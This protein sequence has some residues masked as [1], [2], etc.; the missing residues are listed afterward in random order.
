M[1]LKIFLYFIILSLV[2]PKAFSQEKKLAKGDKEFYDLAYIDAIAVYEKVAEKG[3]KSAGLF[4]KLGDSYYFNAEFEK[5]SKWYAELFTLEEKEIPTEYFYRYAQSLKAVGAYQK[6][7]SMLVKF[8]TV[9]SNEIR[10]SLFQKQTNYKEVIASNSGRY[11]IHDSGINSEY[12][13][14]GSSFYGNKIV[15]ASARDTGGVFRRNHKWTNE[16][17]TELYMVEDTANLA[18]AKPVK[19]SK[20]VNSKFNE[21]T[22]VFSK[23][24]QTLYFTRNNF[25][26]GKKGSDKNKT[27]LL[28]IYKA[29][30]KDSIWT[31]IKALAFTDDQ[32]NTAHPAL[33]ADGKTLYF[34]SDMPG[35]LGQS[36]LFKVEILADGSFG[37][38][39]H[40]GP[41]INTEGK[42]TF[43]FVSDDNELYFAS[44]GHPGL[45][46][47]DIFV[48][49]INED[50]AFAHPINIG[51]PVNSPTDD[52]AFIINTT[53][54]L[55]FFTSYR[56]G[57]KGM[58]DIYKFKELKP[59]SCEQV[60]KG[61]VTDMESGAVLSGAKVVLL[62]D[63]F[64]ELQ[65]MTATQD[66]MYV[67]QVAC[68]K[69]YHVRAEKEA[70]ETA[71]AKIIVPEISGETVLPI[72]PA[73]DIKPFNVGDDIGKKLAIKQIYFDL[74]KA[75]IRPD[76]EVELA[77][78]LEVLLQY[79][80]MRIDV[81]SHTDSRDSFKNN[82][83]LSER[84][85][86]STVAW[87]VRK[88]I[89]PERISGKGYGETQLI[90][91]C[92][93]GVKCSEEEHQLNRRSEFIILSI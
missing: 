44:D 36:D 1:K 78:V 4:Q 69:I 8:N 73:K 35:T 45:G 50:G 41:E 7:D 51:E 52:F 93:D 80:T 60:L 57:G 18:F 61:Q 71:E 64:V 86:Q 76:A 77:K 28:K 33:S 90:N 23:D 20:D 34:A 17:F 9:S 16:A 62:D 66:G 91:Q 68:G 26:D 88:G 59:L 56:K 75:A 24:G 85:A 92:A 39:I 3:Y 67:F 83:K 84:R 79:P 12:S 38:P 54:K 82:E 15:F 65:H 58:D 29:V 48:S 70:Y 5:A 81:R 72:A 30:F 32:Y 49:K 89:S 14:Y 37:T 46:G 25:L 43:P 13:D 40:L 22:P 55:G 63:K 27:T 47:L 2:L 6:A 31:D 11:Y 42:E 10:S 21:S 87:F 74:G 19:F 53:S